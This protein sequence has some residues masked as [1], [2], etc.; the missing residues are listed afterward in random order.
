MTGYLNA[1][2]SE[3]TEDDQLASMFP[4]PPDQLMKEYLPEDFL[5][6]LAALED[7]YDK[8]NGGPGWWDRFAAVVCEVIHIDP[9]DNGGY[10][11]VCADTDMTSLADP[12]DVYVPEAHE[13]LVDFAVGSKVLITGQVWKTREDEMRISTNGWWGFDKIAPMS[14]EVE[15]DDTEGWDA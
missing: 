3:F 13:H 10:I 1:R 14:V 11:L 6:S 9:R 12:V 7:Y 15:S 2:V 8:H 4:S 5:P